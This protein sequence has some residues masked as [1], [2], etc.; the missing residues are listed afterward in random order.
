MPKIEIDNIKYFY[1]ISSHT[2]TDSFNII[3]LH[4]AG[5]DG[6]IWENQLDQLGKKY[7]IIIPDLPAHG[8]SKGIVLPS[9]MK[10]AYWLNDF[11]SALGITG[12]F[13]AGHSLGGAIAQEF[14]RAFPEKLHGLI[15]VGTG[16]KFNILREYLLLV[17]HDFKTAVQTSCMSAY[18]SPV[19][20]TLY[21]KG[22]TMLM[23][24]GQDTL[25]KDMLTC[26]VF[27]SH[28][29]ISSIKKPALVICG[30]EDKITPV[31]MSENMCRKISN[32][33]L[34]IIPGAG[35]MIMQERPEDFNRDLTGF[36]NQIINNKN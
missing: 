6:T 9:A 7:K 15:L 32:S 19:S 28:S 30:K 4:G 20:R 23:Q 17:L 31:A 24:N 16:I 36:V 18:C 27:S 21:E 22:R 5:G 1:L 10:Y 25:H 14:A 35:H 34:K 26:E 2:H 12:F 11:I 33:Q 3:F 8:R 29:W 13:L